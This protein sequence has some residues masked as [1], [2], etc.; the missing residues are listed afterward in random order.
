MT[1]NKRFTDTF[2]FADDTLI[3]QSKAKETISRALRSD[4]LHHAYLF[5]GPEGSGKKVAALAMAEAINGISNLSDL[6]SE[7][8]S[9]KSTWLN[10]PDIHLFIPTPS[11]VSFSDLQQRI[12]MLAE[13]PYSMVDF[14]NMPDL[15]GQEK[16]KNRK[17]FYPL[18]YYEKE[19]RPAAFLSP[20]EGFRTVIII[21]Q[22]ETMRKE[23]TN[24]FLKLLEEP[25]DNVMFILTT[26]QPDMLLPT[27]IS[28]CQ[29]IP[30]TP[31]SRED[32][33]YDLVTNRAYDQGNARYLSR[34]CGGNYA[35]TRFFDHE[36]LKSSREKIIQ[37]LRASY[38]VDAVSIVEIAEIW[39]KELNND[40]TIDL[41]NMMEVFLRDIMIW[42]ITKVEDHL[43]NVDQFEVI[44][45]FS[46]KLPKARI[47]EMIAELADLKRHMIFNV[48]I[49]LLFIVLGLRYARLMR[50]LDKIISLEQEWKHFPHLVKI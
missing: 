17:S 14:G 18:A 5:A 32:I 36:N 47:P 21:T 30:F 20:N 49:R 4:R 39:N 19:I 50:G 13:D 33:E 27:I 43:I 28:R 3:G 48:N 35:M 11:S 44:K 16:S 12:A 9:K 38:A 10:H 25:P 34:V 7:S 23:V 6:G 24:A 26:D 40:A 29:L 15:N 2:R 46:E 42:S 45:N 37:F 22:I 1:P 41:L 31:V 8:W